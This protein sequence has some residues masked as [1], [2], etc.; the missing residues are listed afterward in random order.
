MR[1]LSQNLLAALI[2]SLVLAAGSANAQVQFEH[3]V[4]ID[5]ENRTPDN[6]FG[7]NPTFEPG[8]DIQTYGVN[9]K[10]AT[11]PFTSVGLV[12]CYDLGH[13]HLSFQKAYNNGGMNGSDKVAVTLS[14][15]CVAGANPQFRYVDN[16][17]GI[18]Q[19]YFDLA[20]QYGF[21]NR[22]FQTNQG[23]SF[24]SHLFLIAGTSAP[25]NDS[26]LFAS[27][28]PKGVST[29][30]SSAPG[31]IVEMIN[32]QGVYSSMYPCFSTATLIDL[33][34]GANLTWRYYAANSKTIL[35]S[36]NAIS[37]ICQA[38]E[39]KGKL[40]CTGSEWANV[41]LKPAQVLTDI[42]KCN[43][44][45]VAWV[46]PTGQNSDHPVG[47]TGGGPAWVASIVNA[48]GNSNCGYWQNTAILI[49]W[50]DWGG[51][52]DHVPPYLIGQ[53]NGWGESYV[54]GFRVPLLV[55]SAYT[56]AGYVSVNNHDF[57]SMLRFIETNF[58]LGLIGPGTWADSY[59]DDL[60]EFFVSGTPR[61]FSAVPARYGAEHFINST[62]P[63]TPPDND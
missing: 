62:E 55:V 41:I 50:D 58:G 60:M 11:V 14:K 9:S 47:N 59:A 22:M 46:T 2:I 43:L 25:S 3:I 54:Y 32:P 33:L 20:E 15:G 1:H 29:G 56:P 40:S 37:S 4:I 17:T 51:W 16:S 48:I 30:C 7:S 19:P 38:E 61:S 18:V 12:D 23:A 49:T 36:P 53:P 45:N 28:N 34:E 6:L 42:S 35:T 26:D 5:Q 27:E 24:P 13:S 10:G 39:V 21:A 31:T 8:V 57:G 44:A 52:Y 63:D